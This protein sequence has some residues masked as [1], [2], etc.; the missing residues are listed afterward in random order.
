MESN[1]AL[2]LKA[3][4]CSAETQSK[5]IRRTPCLSPLPT[6]KDPKPF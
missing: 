2:P 4:Y 3:E 1:A 5:T 6:E